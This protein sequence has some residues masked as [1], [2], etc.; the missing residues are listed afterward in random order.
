MKSNLICI[1]GYAQT[2]NVYSGK[3]VLAFLRPIAYA[4]FDPFYEPEAAANE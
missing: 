4:C 3:W 1:A 2:Y